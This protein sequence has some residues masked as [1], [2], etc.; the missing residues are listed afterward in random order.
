M[1]KKNLRTCANPSEHRGSNRRFFTNTNLRLKSTGSL[2]LKISIYDE[3]KRVGHF[4]LLKA[5]QIP[6]S[7]TQVGLKMRDG[8]ITRVYTLFFCKNIRIYNRLKTAKN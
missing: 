3:K 2:V 5:P 6:K 7:T 8:D 4:D 1:F